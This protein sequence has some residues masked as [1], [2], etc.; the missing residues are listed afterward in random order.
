MGTTVT[1]PSHLGDT[2]FIELKWLSNLVIVVKIDSTITL[3]L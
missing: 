3:R 2:K 1:T